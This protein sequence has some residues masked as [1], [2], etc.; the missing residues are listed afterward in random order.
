M[1]GLSCPLIVTPS[2]LALQADIQKWTLLQVR[3]WILAAF[4]ATF[5]LIPGYVFNEVLPNLGSE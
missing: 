3:G 4:A 5:L 2:W 1:I